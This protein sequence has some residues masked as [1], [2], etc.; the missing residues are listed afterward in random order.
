MQYS[1]ILEVWKY[2]YE[3]TELKTLFT[4]DVAQSLMQLEDLSVESCS[5]LTRVI[6]AS[7]EIENK[8]IV[9]PELKDLLLKDLPELT[10]FC[11]STGSVTIDI[12]C[13]S[14]EHLYLMSFPQFSNP[15]WDF[16]SKNEVQLNDGQHFNKW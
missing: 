12:K 3:C 14:L 5:S 11:T 13:P 1:I 16:H 8:K 9:L 10:R 15:A 4:S 2:V 6:E 7:E